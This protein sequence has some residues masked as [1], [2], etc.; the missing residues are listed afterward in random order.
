M[1]WSWRLCAMSVCVGRMRGGRLH[2]RCLVVP[3]LEISVRDRSVVRICED[4]PRAIRC[5]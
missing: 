5:C 3:F 1:G 2:R 4:G